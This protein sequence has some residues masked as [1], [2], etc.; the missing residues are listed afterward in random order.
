[1]T[2]NDIALFLMINEAA[3]ELDGKQYSVCNPAMDLFSTWDSDGNTFDFH[4][5]TELLDGWIINGK[6]FREIVST[7]M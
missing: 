2:E 7:I 1:M 6:P 4:G 3:F 5:V